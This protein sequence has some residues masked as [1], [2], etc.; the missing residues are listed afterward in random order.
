[1]GYCFLSDNCQKCLTF[2]RLIRNNKII[3][4]DF[5]HF[6]SSL[7]LNVFKYYAQLSGRV[8]IG[9]YSKSF[10]TTKCECIINRLDLSKT[11]IFINLIKVID[12]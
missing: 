10:V 1:M 11:F 9:T 2:I 7:Q 5:L 3:S 12:F 6:P 4:Y 8:L